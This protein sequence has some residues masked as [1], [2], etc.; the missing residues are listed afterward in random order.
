MKIRIPLKLIFC[1]LIGSVFMFGIVNIYGVSNLTKKLVEEEVKSLHSNATSIIKEYVK[2]Y[3]ESQMGIADKREMNMNLKAVDSLLNARIWVVDSQG[4]IISDTRSNLEIDIN[5]IDENFLD[6]V[7]IENAYYKGIFT[8]PML[9]VIQSMPSYNYTV[10]CYVCISTPMK[11]IEDRSIYIMD[12]FNL[13]LLILLAVLFFVFIYIYIF[14]AIPVNRMIKIT[15]EYSKGNF[16][17]LMNIRSHDEYG[18]LADAIEYMMK[19]L[20]NKDDYQKNF[21]ANISHD[22]RSPLTSIR[23]YAEAMKDG[24]ISYDQQGKYLD[25]ILFETERLN[26]LTTNLLTLNSF[27]LNGAMLDIR[28]FDINDV[29]KKTVEAFEGICTKK[30]IVL[31]LQFSEKETYVEA[32]I[33]KIQQVLHNLIDNAIKFSNTDASIRITTEEKGSKVYIAIRDYGI[34]IPKDNI[35]KIWERFYKSDL[36]RG[37]D[38]KGT[39]L[40][41]SI[42]KEIISAHKENIS[43]ISTEGVGTEFIFTLLKSV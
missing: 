24:T 5:Y 11:A 20:Q 16:D 33:G 43:V 12:V 6:N 17:A 23:G 25:I 21:V 36:S 19:D 9:C 31:K 38:K 39:G 40:G 42:T 37:R 3:Y 22:F 10:K 41:L 8:E 14:S 28:S 18:E 35:N 2:P 34:G 15:K 32:D 4:I 27:E 1:Y 26:K 7:F 13:C 29:I 30:K